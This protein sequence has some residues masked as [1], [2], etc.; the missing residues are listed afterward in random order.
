M[1]KNRPGKADVQTRGLEQGSR[2]NAAAAID[3]VF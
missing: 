2:R 3:L 1:P